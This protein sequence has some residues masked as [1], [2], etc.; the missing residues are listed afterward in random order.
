MLEQAMEQNIVQASRTDAR[1]RAGAE[2]SSTEAIDQN[3]VEEVSRTDAGAGNG[4]EY[5]GSQ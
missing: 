1:A 5:R 4:A 3:I 2:A